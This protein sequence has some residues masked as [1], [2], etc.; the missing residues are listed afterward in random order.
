[1]QLKSIQMKNFGIHEDFKAEFRPGLNA[2][3][4]P[5]GSGKSTIVEAIRFAILGTTHIYGNKKENITANPD[6]LDVK[7][8]PFVEL[9]FTHKGKDCLI[10]R[11][12]DP[13]SQLL[14]IGDEKWRKE[15]DISETLGNFFGVPLSFIDEHVF[16]G[17]HDIVG[18]MTES[19]TNLINSLSRA[20]GIDFI[21]NIYTVLGEAEKKLAVVSVDAE[22]MDLEEKKRQMTN[23]YTRLVKELQRYDDVF[24][25][26]S[27]ICKTPEYELVNKYNSEN[28]RR[29]NRRH[30]ED[31]L[32]T[33]KKLLETL[34]SQFKQ[35]EFDF[36]AA[37]KKVDNLGISNEEIDAQLV[38][39]LKN[40]EHATK[41]DWIA[42]KFWQHTKEFDSLVAPEFPFL[43]CENPEEAKSQ[44]DYQLIKL[45]N[46]LATFRDGKA[47][48][49]TCGTHVD[50]L[51]ERMVKTKKDIDEL[52]SIVSQYAK[53]IAAI[54][55]FER[56]QSQYTLRTQTIEMDIIRLQKQL[57][58]IGPPPPKPA[59][60]YEELV[61]LKKILSE[62][63]SGLHNQS[64][65]YNTLKNKL[66]EAKS[67]VETYQKSLDTL[68][69]SSLDITEEEYAQAKRVLKLYEQV[70]QEKKNIKSALDNVRRN[71]SQNEKWLLEYKSK[72]LQQEN[73]TR[74]LEKLRALRDVFHK[75]NL[76]RDL[77]RSCLKTVVSRINE[78]LSKFDAPFTIESDYSK[79]CLYACLCTGARYDARRL[80][81]GQKTLLAL[82]AR[83]GIAGYFAGDV[84]LLIL[85]EP[86]AA[87]D[88]GSRTCVETAVEIMSQHG[89]KDDMQL[90]VIT[91]EPMLARLCD[92]VLTLSSLG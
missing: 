12:I 9:I 40:K 73:K 83:V 63:V 70:W 77:V 27:E 74:L 82:A 49:P 52:Q 7:V 66:D 6:S 25:D 68:G 13:P 23:E 16:V 2:I 50:H 64:V 14:Q 53:E 8:N 36:F 4:G 29:E 43:S 42:A 47:E 37:Q 19:P 17:Q 71:L 78:N 61:E 54:N 57:A 51:E 59:N 79:L 88:K 38:Q 30:L 24:D 58:E 39:S 3:V 65:R 22:I 34:E 48:C 75:D 69:V 10:R 31:L 18:F 92:S 15:K 80:S 26:V 44:A 46:F 20:F 11:V 45:K 1:M 5:N 87:L 76:Q 67:S 62:S 21:A 84:G 91:H 85:D 86:T 56:E 72:Q 55:Q 35:A 41:Q 89:G 32:A 81:G 90:I 28:E 33:K 60:S